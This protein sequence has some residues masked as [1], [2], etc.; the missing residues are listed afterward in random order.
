[1][2]R[3]LVVTFALLA[4]MVL[5]I[6]AVAWW[7]ARSGIPETRFASAPPPAETERRPPAP[8]PAKSGSAAIAAATETIRGLG[9]QLGSPTRERAENAPTFDVARI[10]ANGDAVIAGRSAPGLAVELLRDGEVHDRTMADS[11]GAFVFV[12]KRLP[13]G[14]Y[15]L[16]LRVT[17][18]DGRVVISK[19][20]VAVKLNA[21]KSAAKEDKAAKEAKPLVPFVA[22]A[23]PAVVVSKPSEE[24]STDIRIDAVE[25]RGSGE[26]YVSGA[27]APGSSVRL[28]LN[29]AHIAAGTASPD[30]HVEFSIRS[31]VKAGEYRIRLER[32]GPSGGVLSRA[33]KPF[34]APAAVSRENASAQVSQPSQLASAAGESRSRPSDNVMQ[35]AATGSTNRGH[36]IVVPNIDTKV[37]IRGD[38]LWRMSRDS[39]GHGER[40]T[41][42][43]GANRSQ[44]RDPD[45]I[46]PGQIFVLPRTPQQ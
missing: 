35:Q 6:G 45:L 29:D 27:S 3:G 21:A 42:I 16:A 2:K 38:N 24:M 11:A 23:T 33:E 19:G 43:Y 13:P 44:I 28:Y 41:V 34:N 32:V 7:L 15:D 14:N 18:P 30:G 25:A 1:M 26:L 9:D 5:G 17:E 12:P 22:P 4:V 39:Y 8:S 31:G 20:S 40:Y 46:Y 10:E 37:V 36:A